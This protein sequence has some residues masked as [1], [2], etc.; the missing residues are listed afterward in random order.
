ML[1]SPFK[2]TSLQF[3]GEIERPNNLKILSSIKE[4]DAEQDMTINLSLKQEFVSQD[5]SP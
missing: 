2:N 5:L 4:D 1:D 3:L